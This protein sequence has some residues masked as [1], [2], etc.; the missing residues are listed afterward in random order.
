M[1]ICVKTFDMGTCEDKAR[2]VCE[3]AMEF[4]GAHALTPIIDDRFLLLN[5]I[6][7]LFTVLMNYCTAEGIDPQYCVDLAETKNILRGR[8]DTME[9]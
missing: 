4:Y 1:K 5:E 9:Q 8:Y 3:E 6:G 7:D 2:K